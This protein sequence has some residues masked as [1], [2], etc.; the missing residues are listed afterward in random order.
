MTSSSSSPICIA[1]GDESLPV[2]AG[3]SNGGPAAYTR[4]AQFG[5]NSTGNR[6]RIVYRKSGGQLSNPD[7]TWI[8]FRFW[9]TRAASGLRR[10]VVVA[11]QSDSLMLSNDVIVRDVTVE[12]TTSTAAASSSSQ[13][14]ELSRRITLY[15]AALATRYIYSIKGS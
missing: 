14:L 10:D 6:I 9:R 7:P 11:T 12:Q 13:S 2:V 4:R 15:C 1:T 3:N 5:H 8:Y